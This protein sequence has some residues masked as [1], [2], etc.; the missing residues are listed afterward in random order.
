M[1]ERARLWEPLV[2]RTLVCF[3]AHQEP[4]EPPAKLGRMPP[5]KLGRMDHDL[6]APTASAAVSDGAAAAAPPSAAAADPAVSGGGADGA[7]AGACAGSAVLGVCGG[8]AST[9]LGPN[10][11][12]SRLRFMDRLSQTVQRPSWR[13]SAGPPDLVAPSTAPACGRISRG[14][15]GSGS[16]GN[17]SGG[18][19]GVSGADG[20]V[21]GASTSSSSSS[22]SSSSGGGAGE[23]DAST[24]R[25]RVWLP[26]RLNINI[27]Q[28][29]LRFG[30]RLVDFL[31]AAKDA[32]EGAAAGASLYEPLHASI[33][34]E[35]GA[36]LIRNAK[37]IPPPPPP[38]PALHR[39][40]GG[41]ARHGARATADPRSGSLIRKAEV[42]SPLDV[43]GALPWAGP[44]VWLVSAPDGN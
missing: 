4:T 25:L 15:N 20:A 23:A 16:C 36:T 17:G 9:A 38:P 40:G 19:G 12:A 13:L 3:H 33:S 24:T 44:E 37:A 26:R 21:T 1:S 8:S 30:R 2:E 5:A 39:S 27:S 43:L 29:Y 42:Q 10:L 32:V 35:D 14:A 34:S 11:E 22:S 28:Q 31:D 41:G 7:G 18:G 6:A